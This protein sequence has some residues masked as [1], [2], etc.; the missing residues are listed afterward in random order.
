MGQ[1]EH[2]IELGDLTDFGGWYDETLILSPDT[3]VRVW[4]KGSGLEDSHLVGDS[5]RGG[6]QSNCW[7]YTEYSSN[8][9]VQT[10]HFMSEFSE[11]KF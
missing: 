2:R 11:R 8:A 1:L 6:K 4:D 9:Q 5:K 7:E 3:H 10:L